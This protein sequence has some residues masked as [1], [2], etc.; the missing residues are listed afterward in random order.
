MKI[1]ISDGEIHVECN[2]NSYEFSVEEFRRRP[3]GVM[4][5][6]FDIGRCAN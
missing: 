1:L 4:E 6:I 5:R 3:R 2:G